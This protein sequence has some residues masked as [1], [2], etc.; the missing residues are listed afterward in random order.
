MR[1]KQRGKVGFDMMHAIRSA[2]AVSRRHDAPV[3]P[4]FRAISNAVRFYFAQL[5]FG[6]WSFVFMPTPI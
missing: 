1:S 3:M 5:F 6:F 4:V 2:Q